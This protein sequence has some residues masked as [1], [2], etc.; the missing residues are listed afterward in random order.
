MAGT[1]ITKR[2]LKNLR[3]KDGFG[4]VVFLLTLYIRQ[5]ADFYRVESKNM[6]LRI[7]EFS[8]NMK[9]WEIDLSSMYGWKYRQMEQI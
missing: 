5:R 9:K 7:P 3:F 1:T 6:V 8:N 4:T 2:G